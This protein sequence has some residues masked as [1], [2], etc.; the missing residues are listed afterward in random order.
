MAQSTIAIIIL[1]AAL[2]LYAIPKMPLSVTTMLAMIAMVVFGILDFGKVTSGF[3]NQVVFLNMGMMILGQALVTTGVAQKVGNLI[4]RFNFGKNET[5]FMLLVFAI[6]CALSVVINGAITVAIMIP[7]VDAVVLKSEGAISRKNIYMPLGIAGTIGNNVLTIGATSTITAVAL[8]EEMGYGTLALTAPTLVNLPAV[9]VVFIMF[10]LFGK[11]LQ[12]KWYDFDDIPVVVDESKV[13]NTA[14]QPVWKQVVV[15][16][17][18]VA[19]VVAMLAGM[20]YG[21]AALIAGTLVMLT[22]CIDEKTAMRSVGW[23]TII[24]VA[25]SIGFSAGIAASGAG[26]VIAN[27]FMTISGPLAKTG[28]GLCFVLFFV[29][30]LISDVM[31]D[32]ACVA[33]M[34][35]IAAAISQASGFNAIPMF[36]AVC[37]GTKVGLATPICVTPMT[38]VATAGYRFKDYL[39]MGGLVN[40]ICMIVTTIMIGIIY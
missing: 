24:V 16:V 38:M 31:S 23:S 37:S 19:V 2:V 34:L 26:E 28:L 4:N 25:G 11:K 33:I 10:A 18:F 1:L 29:S 21:Y 7:I 12:E 22:G 13:S 35:P 6:A 5:M 17:I 14:E 8:L 20:N 15:C 27:F 32:N 39:R 9:I 30:S 36:L 40:L 3:A